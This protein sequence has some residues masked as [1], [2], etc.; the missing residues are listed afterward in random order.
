MQADIAI[1]GAGAAGLSAA[2]FAGEEAQAQRARLKIVLLDG[3]R[4]PGAKIL[5][6]GGGRCNVTHERIT[7]DD[8]C[9]GS[10][11]TIRNVIR[12][13]DEQQTLAWMGSMGVSLKLEPTG[14]YFPT[15]DSARTVLDALR[16]RVEQLGVATEFGHRV[17]HISRED[18]AGPWVVHRAGGAEPVRAQVVVM[19]TGGR[20]LP[21]SGSDG[22][23]YGWLQALGH[24]IVTP[25]PALAPLILDPRGIPQSPLS[26][27]FAELSG[28]S[29][30]ARL[31]FVVAGRTLARSEGS[32]L[33]THF[34]LSGPA[35][36][37]ISRHIARYR[38]QHPGENPGH[39]VLGLPQFAGMKEADHWLQQQTQKRPR[40]AVIT[41]LRELLPDRVAAVLGGGVGTVKLAQL[42]REQRGMLARQLA[43][44]ALAVKGDRGY[45]FAEAT[46]GGVELAE[47]NWRTMESR[48]APGLFLC[49]EVL[50]VDGRIGGFN[51][52]WAWSSGYL[53]G[54]GA[55]RRQVEMQQPSAGGRAPA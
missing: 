29:L 10:S 49:G 31:E 19:A 23:G 14:K 37:N 18:A 36:M 41:L 43:G 9:G 46:A 13:F 52:Q 48:V 16:G 42:T 28:L 30:E 27:A 20:A 50:D 5:V 54:R 40:V 33:F 34:G 51:F 39:L 44:S 47:V 21:K 3:A 24:T 11:K 7:E 12:S 53:A 55:V 32:V 6:S 38:Q 26:G 1:V 22:A 8:Y 17:T 2:I 15:T 35:P 4:K 25:V 45:S